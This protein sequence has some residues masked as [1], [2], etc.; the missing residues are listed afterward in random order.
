MQ[1][2]LYINLSFTPSVHLSLSDHQS[3]REDPQAQENVRPP[4][5]LGNRQSKVHP[6]TTLINSLRYITKLPTLATNSG[7]Q[8]P[9]LYLNE[10]NK[11]GASVAALL[12]CD[13]RPAAFW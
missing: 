2:S 9:G 5:D 12:Y 6:D 11:S 1:H 13:A 4:H 10:L 8:K 3:E 7:G